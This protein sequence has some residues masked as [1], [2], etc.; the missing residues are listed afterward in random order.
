M[1]S[2]AWVTSHAVYVDGPAIARGLGKPKVANTVLIG[3]LSRL[4]ESQALTG[5]SL[6]QAMWLEVLAGR[7]PTQSVDLNRQ[8]FL[9]RSVLPPV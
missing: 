4:L 2:F 8:A 6:S 1:R 5:P 9:A 7:V 3:A